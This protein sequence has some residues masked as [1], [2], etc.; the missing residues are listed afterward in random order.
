MKMKI[1]IA[2]IILAALL[3]GCSN[4]ST[5]PVASSTISSATNAATAT[6]VV[7]A[8][9]AI[10][11]ITATNNAVSLSS[12]WSTNSDD[13]LAPQ[14]SEARQNVYYVLTNPGAQHNL[15]ICLQGQ[16]SLPKSN[17]PYATVKFEC[18]LYAQ[19]EG[20]GHEADTIRAYGPERTERYIAY[21][22]NGN[23]E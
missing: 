11:A 1:N 3:A 20:Q 10:M 19:H 13:F 16:T 5:A 21:V 4:N 2:S 18:V 6:N 7:T 17:D 8:S 22:S 12:R 14:W 23:R 9:N 15:T